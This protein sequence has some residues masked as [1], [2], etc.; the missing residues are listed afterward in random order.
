MYLIGT[1]WL[2]KNKLNEDGHVSRNKARLVCKGYS[3]EEGVDYG[4]NFSL[5]ARLEGVRKLLAYATHKGFKV[6]QI[7]VKSTLSILKD[8]WIQKRRTWFANYT[9]N[10]MV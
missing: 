9:K 4:K 7:Y 5:V 10:F 3:Q 8:S 1:K 2:F 6:Y